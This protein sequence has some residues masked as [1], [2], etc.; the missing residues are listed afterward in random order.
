MKRGNTKGGTSPAGKETLS[1]GETK[2][3]GE[4][5][6]NRSS[7]SSLDFPATYP[8]MDD[9]NTLS[10]IEA[11]RNG[12]TVPHFKKL[13]DAIPFS[14]TEWAMYLQLS[15]RTIQRNQKENKR[16]QPIHSERIIELAML[17]RYG[18]EV[19]G[20]KAN[21]DAWLVTKN[22]ALGG[23]TPKE[24]LDTKFGIGMVKDELGR[25]EHGVLA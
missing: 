3:R 9:K 6:G 1:R 18:V 14:L 4:V 17:Y 23:R 11:V 20:N 19:F 15:E 24:L 16:F 5:A 13:T 10:I 12:V 7:K 25:I 21:F 22:M 2:A 8:A